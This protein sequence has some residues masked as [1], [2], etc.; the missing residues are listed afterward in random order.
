MRELDEELQSAHDLTIGEF[1]V[2]R[3]LF[4]APDHRRRM[5]DLAEAVVL[6]ASGLSRR[7]DRLERAGWVSRERSNEDGRSVETVL[8]DD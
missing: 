3:A 1:D 6:T 2:L 5:C 7:V 8:T 4:T